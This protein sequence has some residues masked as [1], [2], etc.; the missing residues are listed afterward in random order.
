MEE[1]LTEQQRVAS[2]H[3]ERLGRAMVETR[4]IEPRPKSFGEMIGRMCAIDRRCGWGTQD[5]L[6]GDWDGHLAYLHNRERAVAWNRAR[7]R[8][9]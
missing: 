2:A 9:V 8:R 3:F 7:G 5:P 4:I 1:T 6:G